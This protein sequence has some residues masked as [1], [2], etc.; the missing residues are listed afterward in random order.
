MIIGYAFIL[1]VGV[2]NPQTLND[3]IF[4]DAQAWLWETEGI[5]LQEIEGGKLRLAGKLKR[6]GDMKKIREFLKS[7]PG[8]SDEVEIPSDVMKFTFKKI[9]RRLKVLSPGAKLIQKGKEFIVTGNIGSKTIEK[10]KDIYP[11]IRIKRI[12]ALDEIQASVFLEIALVEV[13]RTA[14]KK[15]GMRMQ[16]PVQLGGVFNLN[17]LSN[18]QN[19][20]GFKSEDPV[21]LFLDFAMQKGQARIHAKQSLV[22]QNGK[23]GVFHVGGEFPI[24][25]VQGY[26]SRV[27]FKNFGLLLKFTPKL[28]QSP[29]VHLSIDSEM[30]EIDTGS[31]VDGTPVIS[32]KRLKTQIFAKLDQTIAIGGIVRST[33]S[34]FSDRIPALSSIPI[35]G[36][37]FRSE[38]FKRHRSEA[39][40]F[41]TARRMNRS[42][43]PSPEL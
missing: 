8:V 4:D 24:K 6:P 9:E 7:H 22:T 30:S 31:L 12:D 3:K 15:L 13:K 18:S 5:S 39:Y 42:W 23:E 10:L 43:M 25:V 2:A 35:L 28:V 16:S 29:M 32:K 27:E 26:V 17:F 37:L 40:I 14:L 33:Q 36:R 38:D 41:V 11:F 20:L 34:K 19:S 21:R 1:L